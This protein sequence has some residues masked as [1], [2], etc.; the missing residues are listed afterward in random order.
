M[1]IRYV[2]NSQGSIPFNQP[3]AIYSSLLILGVQS[4]YIH[5]I[6]LIDTLIV[7]VCR[8][9]RQNTTIFINNDHHKQ[10]SKLLTPLYFYIFNGTNEGDKATNTKANTDKSRCKKRIEDMGKQPLNFQL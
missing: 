9:F 4:Y 8:S 7:V 3:T 1:S 5:V 10:K 6:Y 2:C